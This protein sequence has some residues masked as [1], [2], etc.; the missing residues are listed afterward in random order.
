MDT[1]ILKNNLTTYYQSIPSSHSICIG[2]YVKVGSRHENITNNGITHMLEHMHFRRLNG[3][4]EKEFYK[5][6]DKMGTMLRAATYKEFTRYTLKIR[7]EFL[8]PSIQLIKNLIAFVSWNED[9]LEQEKKIVISEFKQRYYDDFL[10]SSLESFLWNEHPLALPIIGDEEV[11]K[12]IDVNEIIAYKQYHYTAENMAIVITGNIQ[13]DQIGKTNQLLSEISFPT[14]NTAPLCVHPKTGNR[15]P[16]IHFLPVPS[17][18]LD[19]IIS[20]DI[21]EKCCEDVITLLNCIVGSG[22]SSWLQQHFDGLKMELDSEIYSEIKAYT[23]A[24]YISIHY[25]IDKH[26]LYSSFQEVGKILN[27]AKNSFTDEDLDTSKPYYTNN[28]WFYLDDN[29]SLNFHIGYNQH[30]HKMKPITLEEKYNAFQNITQ[31]DLIR[32]AKSIF[33]KENMIILISGST[34]KLTKRDIKASLQL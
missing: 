16:D 15:K 22:T 20:F 9:D 11:I 14:A 30:L 6:T 23:D 29:E 32:S 13:K 27:Q 28:L 31:D 2:L 21:P 33:K 19:V 26:K 10:Q 5:Y 34:S 25:S 7:P 12:A 8:D 4:N 1:F 18:I 3:L 17:S 24:S